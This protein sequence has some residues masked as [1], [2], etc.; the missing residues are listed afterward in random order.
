[1]VKDRLG[2]INIFGF[3]QY[4][5]Q[6]SVAGFT[7]CMKLTSSLKMASLHLFIFFSLFGVP[8]PM[9]NIKGSQIFD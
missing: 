2:L 6:S 4:R 8:Y 1:M 3:K 9:N 7:K 5:F